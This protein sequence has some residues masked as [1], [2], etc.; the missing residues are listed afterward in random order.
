MDSREFYTQI[1]KAY[2]ELIDIKG[3]FGALRRRSEGFA[4]RL[5][6][7]A[8]DATN[9]KDEER[10]EKFIFVLSSL[11]ERFHEFDEQWHDIGAFLDNVRYYDF[12]ELVDEAEEMTNEEGE[13]V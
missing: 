9:I 2:K 11:S 13:A 10:S 7:L 1:D 8:N 12:I 5:E 4:C 6:E 3:A